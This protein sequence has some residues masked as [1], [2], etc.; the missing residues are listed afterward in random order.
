MALVATW[1]LFTLLAV[2]LP[3]QGPAPWEMA[4]WK[5]LLPWR[6]LQLELPMKW[7]SLLGSGLVLT[8]LCLGLMTWLWR[9]QLHQLAWRF[10]AANLGGALLAWPFKFAFARPRPEYAAQGSF[11]AIGYAFPSGHAMASMIFYGFLA[12]LCLYGPVPFTRRHLLACLLVLWGSLS[13]LSRFYLGDHYLA[14]VLAGY[15]LGGGWLLFCLP[16]RQVSNV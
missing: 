14:D 9:R 6:A 4:T 11:D 1:L 12:W 13:G 10:L 16:A 3:E 8:P 5:A 7:I 15:C 2:C